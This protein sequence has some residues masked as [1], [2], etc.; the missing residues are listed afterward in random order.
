MG[1]YDLSKKERASL[2]DDIR[3]AITDDLHNRDT[4]AIKKYFSDEDTYIRKA[5]YTVTGKLYRTESALKPGILKTIKT[6]LSSE[7]EIERQT[8]MNVAGEI[9]KT[10]FEP[11]T[12]F[13]DLALFDKHHRVRNAVI[14]SLKKVSAKNPEPALEWARKYLH[15]PNR[16][17]RREI[18]HGIELRG[19][20]H[21]QDILPLLKELQF[22][23]TSRVRN[24]LIHVLGQIS[25]KKGCL[26]TVVSSLSK[27]DNREL[28]EKAMDEIV[29]VHHRYKS[30]AVM[31]QSEVITYIDGHYRP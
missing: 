8:A 16:E 12:E 22:D 11:V 10:D 25:Y 3:N 31:T 17:V 7:N 21:P 14:G 29:D 4:S 18:C 5:A 27:W 2:V 30:F 24:T 23:P 6:M 26:T 28:V 9:G 19:R 15:H 1:F 20:T 13:F